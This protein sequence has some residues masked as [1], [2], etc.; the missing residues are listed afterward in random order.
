MERRKHGWRY[1]GRKVEVND[2]NNAIDRWREGEKALDTERRLLNEA[3]ARFNKTEI[4]QGS[5]RA[6]GRLIFGLDLTASREHS[7]QRARV[8]TA[9]MFGTVKAIGAIAVKLIYYRGS[10]ECRESAWHDDPAVLSEEMQRLSCEA[11]ETQ[12]GR[13]LLS[14]LREKEKLAGVVFV[15]DHCEDDRGELLQAAEMLGQKSI[16]LFIFHE[17]DDDDRRS[18]KAKPI[19]K[20]MAAASGGEYVEFKPDSS[21]ALHEMLSNVAA[22]SAGGVEGVR[23]MPA[24]KTPEARQLQ[25]RLLLGDGGAAKP[26]AL[27]GFRKTPGRG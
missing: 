9:A 6:V 23:Q 16:P 26:T 20:S 5:A 12:I 15:G 4:K 7:L 14:A 17:C 24:L 11:G 1:M 8:A 2:M 18:L 3:L 27:I 10:N 19:F 13:I 21:A 22:F 25:R